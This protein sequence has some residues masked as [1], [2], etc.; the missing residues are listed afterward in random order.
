MTNAWVSHHSGDSGGGS[1]TTR[2]L[3]PPAVVRALG[4]FDLDPAGAPGHE[5]ARETYL[6]ERGQDGLTLPWRGRVWLNPPYDRAPAA[7]FLRKMVQHNHGSA[8]IFAR[9]DTAIFHEAV[10]G[11]ATSVLFIKGRLTFLDATGTPAAANSGAASCLVAYGPEDARALQQAVSAGALN[12]H[13]VQ[14]ERNQIA[15]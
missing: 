11:A 3:T 12:G 8:L 5:L 4:E 6:L 7:A 13:V 1:R 14:I 9:T 2:W 10:W 15:A